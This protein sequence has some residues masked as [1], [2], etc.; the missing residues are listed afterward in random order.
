MATYYRAPDDE[1]ETKY[2]FIEGKF[3]GIMP[4]EIIEGVK[5]IMSPTP[6]SSHGSVVSNIITIFNIYCWNTNNARVFGDNI[7]VH[8]PDGS[9]YRPDVTVIRDLSII[10]PQDTIYGVPDLIVEI[11]SRST[12]NKDRGIK[13][14]VYE[15][16]GV[17]EYWIVD[18]WNKSIEVYHLIDGKFKFDYIYQ[19]Y[20]Q[21]ELEELTDEER[22]EVRNEIKVSIF[23]DLMV[24]IHK[25]FMWI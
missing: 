24:D 16:N 6:N 9:L 3:C 15:K 12:M 2:E 8:L 11:L 19:V 20:S 17:K 21:T 10:K 13:K 22:A 1:E 18:T 4:Y 7:D 14:D 23:D 25:V 5:V